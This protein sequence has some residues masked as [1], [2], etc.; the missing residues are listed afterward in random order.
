[1]LTLFL[2]LR[3]PFSIQ[4]TLKGKWVEQIQKNPF[5]TLLCDEITCRLEAVFASQASVASEE[6]AELIS[7]TVENVLHNI[8][9]DHP[10][11]YFIHN[12]LTTQY[13]DL[14]LLSIHSFDTSNDAIEKITEHHAGLLGEAVSK[15]FIN[16]E[17]ITEHYST[18]QKHL[19]NEVLRANQVIKE[20]KEQ[21][22]NLEMKTSLDPLTNAYNR[23]ALHE[24]LS[25]VLAKETLVFD[26]FALMIDIDNFKS[27]NDQFGHI[28]GDKVLIFVT[29]LLKKAVRDGDRVYRF[30]GE[31]FIILINRTDMEG[32]IQASERLL[33]LCR[34]NQPLFQNE[35]IPVTLS[36]GLTK[37]RNGDTIDSIIERSDTALYRAKNNGKD[38]MEMEL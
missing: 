28:A 33:H 16:Y 38:R 36:I 4:K 1:M 23:Y 12:A 32:A 25:A 6:L 21:I 7:N 18:F 9:S 15:D 29:K 11:R 26:I 24:Y 10:E 3:E 37:I 35:Q 13:K 34:T 17:T 2:R 20:L 27:I 19:Q 5:L 14:A 8:G 30:G 22:N 31:E